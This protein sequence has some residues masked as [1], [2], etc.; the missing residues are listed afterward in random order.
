[1]SYSKTLVKKIGTS[2]GDSI[3]IYDVS[4][5]AATGNITISDVSYAKVLGVSTLIED[6]DANTD[7]VVVQAKEDSTTTNQINLKLWKS[8]FSAATT[9]K[10]FRLVLLCHD[11]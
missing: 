7:H 5:D 4:P 6:A 1:M 10:D 11:A 2:G 3:R 9:F 8:S